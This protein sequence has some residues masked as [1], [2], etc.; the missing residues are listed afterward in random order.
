MKLKRDFLFK[1]NIQLFAEEEQ[2][3]KI[4][5]AEEYA[6]AIK[7]LKE[8]TVSKEAYDKVVNDNKV[9]TKALAEGDPLPEGAQEGPAPD[10]KELR[11]K[12]LESGELNLSNAEYVQN[13]LALRKALIDAGEV[14]PFI[15]A[16]VKAKPSLTD[17]QGAQ[18]VAEALETWLEAARDSET[19]KIDEDIFNAMLK[20]GIAEDNP[21]IRARSNMNNK[22]R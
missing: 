13:A 10:I 18:K 8:N 2:P 22:K 21:L 12:F 1:L 15:P 9:L 11:K 4:Q 17:I 6:A 16:G 19:G 3:Q 5:T 7:N 20:K 14:D